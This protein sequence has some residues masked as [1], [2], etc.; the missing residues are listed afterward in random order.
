MDS[1]KS[2]ITSWDEGD[3][4]AVPG[5]ISRRGER[6]DHSKRAE[7]RKRSPDSAEKRIEELERPVDGGLRVHKGLSGTYAKIC[8]VPLEFGLCR[9]FG[10][11][12]QI[13]NDPHCLQHD[14]VI[15]NNIR[16]REGSSWK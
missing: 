5:W 3:V 4:N 10:S 13:Q 14:S 11:G 1:G 9:H 8:E 12:L 6:S 16:H 7:I 15:I 2:N